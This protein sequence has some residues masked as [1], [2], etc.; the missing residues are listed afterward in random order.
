LEEGGYR[1]IQMTRPQTLAYGLSDSP[2][3]LAGWL[4]EK[5]RAWSDCD[6]DVEKVFSKDYLI[7]N[8]ML[9]WVTN[10]ISTAIR[11]YYE[12]QHHQWKLKPGDRVRV[13]TGFAAFPKEHTPIIKSRAEQYFDTR[14]FTAMP[15]GG[16]FAHYEA[17]EDLAAEIRAFFRESRK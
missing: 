5:C 16:H 4:I 12:S 9:Y 2:V 6:G 14:R 8:A 13:P 3:G 11:I 1:H 10:S 7:T 15:R 17:P